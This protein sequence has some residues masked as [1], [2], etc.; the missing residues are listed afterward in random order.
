MEPLKEMF[1]PAYY[2]TLAHAIK[3][4]CKSFAVDKFLNAVL[5]PIESM[6]LNERMHHT[7]NV[8]HQHLPPDYKKTLR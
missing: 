7:T 1:G 8:L 2:K 5:G 4:S 3:T 6:A